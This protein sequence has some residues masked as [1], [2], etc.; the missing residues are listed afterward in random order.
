MPVATQTSPVR[1]SVRVHAH[2]GEVDPGEW[3]SLLSDEDLQ[4]SHRFIRACQD[5]DVESAVYRHVM[6]ERSGRL[7]A[8]A[9]LS[10][11]HVSLD[12]LSSGRTRDA[13]RWARNWRPSFLRVP[14]VMCGLP[15]SFG[16]SCV[17][18]RSDEDP[19]PVV[20]ALASC[21]DSFAEELGARLVCFKEFTSAEAATF[22]RL[23]RHDYF[24]AES[25]PFCTLPVAWKSFDEYLGSLRAGY[26]RQLHGS[27]SAARAAGLTIRA[28]EDFG[29]ECER[30]FRLY[31]QVMERA[32][33]QLERLNLA[34][35]ERL[36]TGFGPQSFALLV[37]RD[38]N[39][40][41][42]AILL[43]APRALTFLLA[44]IDYEQ[45]RECQAYPFLM[46]HIVAE[47]IRRGASSLELGQTSYALKGRFGAIPHSRCFY[48]KHRA[49]VRNALLRVASGALFPTAK[50][51]VR[52]VFKGVPELAPALESR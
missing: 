39:L 23:R 14:M 37:E 10:C 30:I 25:L 33:F 52:H 44:G 17:R 16:S 18:I 36:N 35:F 29:P 12:L 48:L 42:A 41:A 26:R 43:A 13:I 40:V 27:M 51:A 8:V 32:E 50:P 1:L 38:G 11:M 28:A 49:G 7:V 34:Y 5:S 2:I 15:V 9:T 46:T 19:A 3:D 6:I 47:A 24:R 20:D 31:E 45:N 4:T 21:A 22:D